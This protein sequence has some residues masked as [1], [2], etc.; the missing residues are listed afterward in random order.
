MRALR[1]LDS[2]ARTTSFGSLKWACPK[3]AQP[4]TWCLQ[5]LK[6][7]P[8]KRHTQGNHRVVVF[9][10]VMCYF[11]ITQTRPSAVVDLSGSHAS[12][13]KNMRDSFP[14]RPPSQICTEACVTKQFSN[15]F[16][17]EISARSTSHGSGYCARWAQDIVLTA[18]LYVLGSRAWHWL[19]TFGLFQQLC[20][21]DNAEQRQ[22][23]LSKCLA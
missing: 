18:S 1:G 9:M 21:V 20:Y 6:G 13:F 5:S 16:T 22:T 19:W 7:S 4:P 12:L 11:G 15:R 10:F 8:K 23:N 17:A 14:V 2:L 3:T